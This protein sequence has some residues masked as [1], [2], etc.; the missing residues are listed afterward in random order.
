MKIMHQN[1]VDTLTHL[2]SGSPNT[3]VI[4]PSDSRYAQ[5]RLIYNRMH[6]HYPG[7]IIQTLDLDVLRTIMA[8]AF[9]H[10]IVLAIRGGG[11]HIGGFSTCHGGIMLDFSPFKAIHVDSEQNIASVSPGA[12][13]ADVDRVLS[14]HGYIVPTGTVSETGI[15]G[16]TLGGGIGWLVGQYGLTCDQLCGADVLLADGQWVQ[17]EDPMH[18]D[19]LWGLR[20]GGG[21]FG[22]VTT[23]RYRL[24]PLPK[25]TCGMGSVA[26][27]HVLPVMDALLTYLT[28]SC[29]PSLTV[30][31]VFIKENDG[32][33]RLRIDF[34]CTG[35]NP[36]DVAPLIALSKFVTWD[37]VRAW[38]FAEWQKTFDQ[39]FLPPMRGY[40]KASYQET[41]SL[42]MIQKMCASFEQSPQTHC[43]I[44][45][46]HLH[47]AFKM[48][49][50]KT[51]AFPL[52][53][54]NFGVLFSI[55][56]EHEEDDHTH[57]HW[58]RESFRA[59]D[60]ED[61]SETYLNYTSSDDQR[62]VKTLLT[63][64]L[65]KIERVKSYYDPHNRFKRNHNVLPN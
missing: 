38:D 17:A 29:P 4:T 41:L 3:E 18:H 45:F 23:F 1:N 40:W 20:G 60:P 56:W 14:K 39:A 48:H 46:E 33:P 32:Q 43:T 11:H 6:D 37:Q 19:L 36:E 55:R 25:T 16:L 24:N 8:Y 44:M 50:Q 42:D 21:N 2:M 58:I 35:N 28:T 12:C 51:S 31:P 7:L 64:T 63:S 49:D 61:T 62:A 59:I 26:W 5:A 13:L 47:G 52:R 22:I 34:C 27:E 54:T 57:I 65:S 9:E 10:D 53:H 30:A 15:A